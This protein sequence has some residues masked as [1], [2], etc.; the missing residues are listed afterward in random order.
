MTSTVLGLLLTTDLN[1]GQ[2]VTLL[3]SDDG[4]RLDLP[5]LSAALTLGDG[6][7]DT[8]IVEVEEYPE[9]GL[10]V[11]KLAHPGDRPHNQ[12][13]AA[14]LDAAMPNA[15]DQEWNGAV[16]VTGLC[17][18]GGPADLPSH[19]Y[20]LARYASDAIHATRRAAV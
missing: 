13:A 20:D 10:I 12:V 15:A 4:D 18:C 14:L 5:F 8:E 19:I 17:H 16:V 11:A 7:N 9:P 6:D 2:R 3:V 1:D